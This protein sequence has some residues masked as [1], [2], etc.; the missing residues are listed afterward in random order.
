MKSSMC[1][2]YAGF[3]HIAPSKTSPLQFA[4]VKKKNKIGRL[5]FKWYLTLSE[6]FSLVTFNCRHFPVEQFK[7]FH[8]FRDN[9]NNKRT[10]QSAARRRWGTQVRKRLLM[11][12]DDGVKRWSEVGSLTNPPW[13]IEGINHR[14]VLGLQVRMSKISATVAW[15]CMKQ[16]KIFL[17]FLNPFSFRVY[18]SFVQLFKFIHVSIFK[19]SSSFTVLLQVWWS[20][21]SFALLGN[22]I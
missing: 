19:N 4:K 9:N 2:P 22:W 14:P 5:I 8:L 20:I 10:D 3:H 18:V 15:C 7:G 6:I 16:T 13:G 17:L 12:G 1:L 11:P 21:T